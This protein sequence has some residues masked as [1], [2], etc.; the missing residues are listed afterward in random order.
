MK[1]PTLKLLKY[2]QISVF[3]A[4]FITMACTMLVSC[5]EFAIPD[6]IFNDSDVFIVNKKQGLDLKEYSTY[7][8]N[9]SLFIAYGNLP[10]TIKT[11]NMSAPSF[12]KLY[13]EK[14]NALGYKEV[15]LKEKPD[16]G[17]IISRASDIVIG[18]D[19][20]SVF[21]YN[22]YLGYPE[23]GSSGLEYPGNSKNYTITNE[24]WDILAVDLKNATKTPVLE[25]LYNQQIWTNYIRSTSVYPTQI[26][27]LFGESTFL[28]K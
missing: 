11:I 20:P 28:K 2:L 25:V 7:S 4:Y 8:L 24:I 22:K 15:D 27:R 21:S 13:R 14:M 12:F 18:K 5:N 6:P 10:S 23:L 3:H 19:S 16:I 9:D 1:M 17:I 26:D